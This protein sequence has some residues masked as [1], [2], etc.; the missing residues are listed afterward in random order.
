MKKTFISLVFLLI[1][2]ITLAQAPESFNYQA[3]VRDAS[4]NPITNQNV[5]FKISILKENI[6]GTV[7]YSELHSA[8]TNSIGLVNLVIGNGTDKEGN[9]S[10]IDWGA[11][12]Y[13]LKVE[14]DPEGGT[15][16]DEMG[17]TQL[18]SVPYA[19]YSKSVETYSETDPNA[20]L[21][22]GDQTIDGNKT[23][24]GT[25]TVPEPVNETDAATKAY[26]DDLR[27]MVQEIQATLGVTDIDGNHYDVVIIGNQIW[28]AEN[29]KATHYY[30]GTAIPLITDN[31]EWNI[32]EDN[33]TDYAYCYYD[34]SSA[35]ASI[36]GALY[37]YAAATNGT[38]HDGVN[39]VQG[40]C[41][42]G[43]HVPSEAEW[44]ELTDFL[45]GESVAG[46]KMK[47][48]GFTHWIS[49]NTGAD[50]SV[51]FSG[52]PG[53]GRDFH[54]GAGMFY[55]LG[56]YEYWWSASESDTYYARGVDLRHNSAEAYYSD[57]GKS[58][59]F[60]VRCIKD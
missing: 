27:S 57:L 18:L 40:V 10:F 41:P 15:F 44:I 13:F 59:G 9:I 25:T 21:L 32:L 6:S 36:Y 38:P 12:S 51:A 43:W 33:N 26:V 19:L 30:N 3:V 22:T 2:I 42:T 49:P 60:A 47:E 23:F 8:T 14:I 54:V 4:N 5:S 48:I 1:Y 17:T 29:M 31:D 46:G 53:G 37:T 39:K 58:G 7:E 45:G 52:L 56:Y 28:M 20:V 55:G 35:N 34:N 16:Y 11:N 50:N 24:T